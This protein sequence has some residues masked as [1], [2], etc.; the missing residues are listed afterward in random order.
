MSEL[1]IDVVP[2]FWFLLFHL[3]KVSD[4]SPSVLRYLF[5]W[6]SALRR[7]VLARPG[8]SFS[9]SSSSLGVNEGSAWAAGPVPDGRTVAS[10]HVTRL[11]MSYSQIATQ[12]GLG[13]CLLPSTLALSKSYY[14]GMPL[15]GLIGTIRSV[16]NKDLK[17]Q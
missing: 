17:M 12:R 8:S 3:F 16:Q 9:V 14:R 15:L 6:K 4:M 5:V 11:T 1:H 10:A 7:R 2:L 13:F